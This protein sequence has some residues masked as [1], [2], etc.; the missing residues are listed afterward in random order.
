MDSDAL[1]REPIVAGILYPDEP[2]ALR[3]AVRSLIADSA[4]RPGS[5][6]ACLTPYAAYDYCGP[7]IAAAV[8][9]LAAH[10]PDCVVL[11]APVHRDYREQLMLPESAAYNTPLRALACD[12]E[13]ARH[14]KALDDRIVTD[15]LPHLDEHAIEV[16][17]PFIATLF[18]SVSVVPVLAGDRTNE[19]AELVHK[20][21]IASSDAGVPVLCVANLTSYGERARSA[22][23]ASM[24]IDFALGGEPIELDDR[25]RLQ[26][27][28]PGLGVICG[29]AR[30]GHDLGHSELL[31]RDS[32]FR[33][34]AESGSTVEYAAIA[35]GDEDVH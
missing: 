11:I 33:I 12:E 6:S 21:I 17:L 24:L 13:Y 14:L 20:V 34:D 27:S 30:A 32:S 35:Y 7:A 4:V 1:V 31:L 2:D 22:T 19:V 3:S 16:V 26:F 9:A 25:A 18:P 29:L 28:T 15:E 8:K 10:T 5:A 23:E